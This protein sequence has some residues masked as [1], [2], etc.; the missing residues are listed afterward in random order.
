MGAE[1]LQEGALVELLDAAPDGILLVS[2]DGRIA[3]GNAAAQQLFGYGRAELL[4]SAIETLV[5][6]RY[7]S[8]HVADRQTYTS[9]PR[10]RPMGLGL[11]LQGL[12][13]DGS[14][15]PV[16]IS[17]APMTSSGERLIVTIV[18]DATEQRAIEE[19]RLRYARSQAV[20]EIVAG[21]EAI[22][23]E[24]TTPD[25]GSLTYLGG[26]EEAFLGYPREQWLEHG[27]WL[28]VVHPDDR[29]AALTFAETANE[30]DTF[31]LEYRLIDHGGGIHHVRDVVSVTRDDGGEVARLRGVIVDVTERRE[32]EGRLS[33]A[34]KMEAVGQLAGGIAHDFNNLLTI[35]S[36]YARRL[37]G[38][39]DIAHAHDDL[40][41]IITATDRAAQLTSQLLTFARRGQGEATLVDPGEAIR[42]LEPMLRRLIDADIVFD[43][44]L[45]RLLPGVLIDRTQL[46]QILMN[47]ILNARDAMP[48]GGTL[49]IASR[50]SSLSADEAGRR[51]VPAGDYVELLLSDTGVGMAPEVR[52]RIFEPFF[53]TKKDRGTGM[54]LAT[55][56]GIIDQAG[57]WIDVESAPGHGTTFLV[58]LPAAA[59]LAARDHE[60]AFGDKPTLLL[61]EDEAA[62][63]QLVV[64]M[65]AEDGYV[66]LQ[67]GNG[68]DAIAL[69]ER[70]RGPIDLLITDV[71]MPRLSGPELAQQLKGL[72]PG[73]EVLFMSGYNDSRLV[74]RGVQ[75]ANVNLLVKPFTPDQLL[76]RVQELT[77]GREG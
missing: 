39:H 17:L 77:A 48:G 20:D 44:R 49:T 38:R 73:L 31:E 27:F 28:S 65:L 52:E 66:V 25:R 18:R 64:T 58:V 46:E 1:G 71:V 34:Q 5:P 59:P 61:V 11:R 45:D 35:A 60:Q 13:R 14:E 23:W 72:R 22:V 69:A 67:A 47:L 41:Q 53:T 10:P 55:V 76:A 19:Q 16:E 68:M 6:S 26:R 3:F 21:L 2:S 32:L 9:R 50:T 29:I 74:A 56:Y 12:R 75:Q 43:F 24:S 37:R 33:E 42:G 62:L 51:G 4:G 70:H 40:D 8:R 7:R 57:G 54:G 15:F 63:R 30:K 36:G